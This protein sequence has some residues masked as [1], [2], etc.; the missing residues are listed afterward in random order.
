[1]QRALNIELLRIVSMLFIVIGHLGG[2]GG[3]WFPL[4]VDFMPQR[5]S[6]FVLI[7]GYF[8]MTSK[9]KFGRILR[10]FTEVL[11]YTFI[12]TFIFFCFGK[13]DIYD[14]FKSI[15]PIAPTKF[16]YWFTT[17]YLGLLLL[18]P[19]LQK[20]CLSLT[21]REYKYLLFSLLLVQST[22]FSF[23]HF[24]ELFNSG[25]VFSFLWMITVFITGGYLRRYEPKFRY[26][27]CCM[28]VL[29]LLYNLCAYFA[30]SGIQLGYNS[31]IMYALAV[32]TFMWFKNMRISDSGLFAKIIA[33][34]SP[35]VFAIYLI[36][37]HGMLRTTYLVEFFK[38]FVDIM[39]NTIYLLL[40]GCAVILISVLVDKIRVLLF[41]K[42]Q[43]NRNISNLGQRVDVYYEGVFTK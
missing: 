37:E 30:D 3:V 2:R 34:M 42:L 21:N 11:F 33:F 39:P 36:H 23:F 28:V 25:K 9:F 38:K 35:N 26:W 27:G 6:C 20:L 24:G 1:M 43:I 17:R 4:G 19:F 16:N 22:F 13:A 41:D 7:S 32:S 10:I 8:L 14:L 40:F 15:F 31:L 5:L 12:I 18:S 29:L